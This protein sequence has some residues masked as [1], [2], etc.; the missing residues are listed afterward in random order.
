MV[1][2]KVALVVGGVVVVGGRVL[3]VE[4]IAEAAEGDIIGIDFVV[5]AAG[6]VVLVV[7]LI[8]VIEENIVVLRAVEIVS[9]VSLIV[10]A[11]VDEVV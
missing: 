3:V 11:G 9:L 10:A 2:R 7:E 5:V 1:L 6:T 4:E 8:A